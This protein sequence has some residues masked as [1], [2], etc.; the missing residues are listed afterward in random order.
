MKVKVQPQSPGAA[1]GEAAGAVP[2]AGDPRDHSVE[3]QQREPRHSPLVTRHSPFG[4]CGEAVY[5]CRQCGK[6]YRRLL[7]LRRHE[8]TECGNKEPAHQCPYCVHK[9][10]Q[11]GGNLRLHMLR[12]HRT[13]PQL[14]RQR[15]SKNCP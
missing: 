3:Q 12:H 8:K 15:R 11:M 9:S 13:L 1:P 5:E 7:C 2:L 6:K 4:L 14:P 10:R